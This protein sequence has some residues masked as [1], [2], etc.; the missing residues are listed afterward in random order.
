MNV[1]FER[2]VNPDTFEVQLFAPFPFLTPFSDLVVAS[3][4]LRT[5]HVE[6]FAGLDGFNFMAGVRAVVGASRSDWAYSA[7]RQF[8]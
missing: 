4:A 6:S 2:L 7:V 8:D 5:V 3:G 1:I